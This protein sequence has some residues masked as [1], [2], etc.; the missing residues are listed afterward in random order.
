[1]L[2]FLASLAPKLLAVWLMNGSP[3]WELTFK[4]TRA[5]YR[6]LALSLLGGDGYQLGGSAVEASRIAPL[7]PLYLAGIYGIA[8]PDVPTWALGIGNALLRAGTSVIVL[9]L[10]YP[11]VG[12]GPA[13]AGALAHAFDPWESFWTPFVGKDALGTFLFALAGLLLQ[14]GLRPRE[15]GSTALAGAAV[16]LA[17]LA[18]FASVGLLVSAL[19]ALVWRTARRRQTPAEGLRV[20]LVLLACALVALT[21]WLARNA[22]LLGSPV[23]GA[24]S[25]GR[26]LYVA[27]ADGL[28]RS[29]ARSGN[30]EA[31]PIGSYTR[32]LEAMDLSASE[33]DAAFLLGALR[34]FRAHPRAFVLR[35]LDKLVGMWRP[36][37]AGSSVRSE[38]LLGLP[39]LAF[40]FCVSLGAL[41]AF[42]RRLN[43]ELPVAILAVFVVGHALL[44]SDIRFRSYLTPFLAAFAGLAL[45][46][47]VGA[48]RRRA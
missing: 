17:T 16:G 14:R 34:Y 9:V 15:L 7:Y 24:H 35:C 41:T 43:V 33:R 12:R 27:N 39:Y 1:M 29:V 31:H 6:P 44:L 32:E 42:S 47:V 48:W 20:A 28:A 4:D 21:P 46:R 10:S 8:G 13:L 22:R 36:T 45:D 38:L 2:V 18:R 30:A 5:T 26:Y 23:L 19:V 40:M 3:Q 37:Y 25:V 11:L